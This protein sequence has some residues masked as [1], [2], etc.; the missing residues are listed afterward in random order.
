MVI[1]FSR[2]VGQNSQGS[3]EASR[4]V[5]EACGARVASRVEARAI[6]AV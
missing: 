1:L 5:V 6:T 3:T 4:T 2:E